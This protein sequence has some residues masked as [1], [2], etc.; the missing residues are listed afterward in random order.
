M[1]VRTVIL[2]L[3]A[4]L[5]SDHLMAGASEYQL[6]QPTRNNSGAVLHSKTGRAHLE[7][8]GGS[9]KS[10]ALRRDERLTTLAEVGSGWI[11][12]GIREKSSRRELVLMSISNSRVDRLDSP[13]GQS[14]RYRLNP[15]LL[16]N[17]SRLEG[18]AWLEGPDIKSLSVR[19]AFFQE[20]SWSN[21]VEVPRPTKGSQSGL[22][23]TLLADGS[24]LLVWAAFDG[25]D[26]D[27]FYSQVIGDLVTR[28]RRVTANNR[29][30]DVMPSILASDS[31]ALLAWSQLEDGDYRIKISR[32]DGSA[33]SGAR[34]H[35]PP[36]SL[37]AQ[38]S[39]Q[40]NQ[41][42]LVYREAWPRSWT[43]SELGLSGR[44]QR[45]A[46]FAVAS[47]DRPIIAQSSGGTVVLRWAGAQPS[48]AA[49]K[50]VP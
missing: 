32:F 23:A 30:P 18:L 35:G 40:D 13:A 25:T 36:G 44:A 1:V 41:V 20:S 38:L 48:E 16:G 42:S 34:T 5:I 31:G 27:I 7:T 14:A 2:S 3:L 10:L 26:D 46:N 45:R 39:L 15:T 49:W 8:P 22:S 50:S 43:V 19:L 33:W 21:P 9:R 29:V 24:W 11:T 28:A 17:D 37:R 6:I 12:A 47:D 4:L